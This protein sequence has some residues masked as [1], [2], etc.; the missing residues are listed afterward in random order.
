MNVKKVT[1]DVPLKSSIPRTSNVVYSRNISVAKLPSREL[2]QP[3]FTLAHASPTPFVPI[4]HLDYSHTLKK[5]NDVFNTI[6]VI[7]G[8]S[9]YKAGVSP[10]SGDIFHQVKQLKKF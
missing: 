5:L 4:L 6:L 2:T 8:L 10:Y 9:L 3:W 7:E 1:F